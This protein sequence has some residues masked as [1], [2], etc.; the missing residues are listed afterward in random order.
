[1]RERESRGAQGQVLYTVVV[2]FSTISWSESVWGTNTIIADPTHL[3]PWR[4]DHLGIFFLRSGQH[5]VQLIHYSTNIHQFKGCIRW[6]KCDTCRLLLV[7][8]LAAITHFQM[9]MI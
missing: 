8:S 1:M 4:K 2:I 6:R 7:S 3:R 9:G 5:L